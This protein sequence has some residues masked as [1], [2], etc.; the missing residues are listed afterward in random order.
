[1]ITFSVFNSLLV[2]LLFKRRTIRLAGAL[3]WLVA[4]FLVIGITGY[5]I[6]LVDVRSSLEPFSKQV[7]DVFFAQGIFLMALNY[8]ARSFYALDSHSPPNDHEPVE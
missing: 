2:I 7:G 5:G 6:S 1:M 4:L 8:A 3:R